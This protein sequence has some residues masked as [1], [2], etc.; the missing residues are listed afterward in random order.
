MGRPCTDG[1]HETPCDWDECPACQ[2]ECPEPSG[3][4]PAVLADQIAD[5]LAEALAADLQ[6]YPNGANHG[7]STG[8]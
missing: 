7:L 1:R 2:E 4:L 3:S 6:Q 5:L 8:S